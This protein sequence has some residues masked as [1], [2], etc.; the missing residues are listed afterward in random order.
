[1]F[2]NL[3]ANNIRELFKKSNG[4]TYINS[5]ISCY[6]SRKA[7]TLYKFV[8]E[9]LY[10][11]DYQDLIFKNKEE[12]AIWDFMYKY[13]RKNRREGFYPLTYKQLRKWY[14]RYN[15]FM[16]FLKKIGFIRESGYQYNPSMNIC[17]YYEINIKSFMK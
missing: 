4:D 6:Q 5:S 16:E 15:E 13:Y 7:N 3:I 2:H 12:L 1:M 11:I 17:K 14:K 8:K 9:I 10:W